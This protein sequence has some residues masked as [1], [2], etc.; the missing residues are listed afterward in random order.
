MCMRREEMRRRLAARPRGV[1]FEELRALLEAYG[2]AVVRIRGSHHV[3][4]RAGQTLAVPLR[5]PHVLA[6]YVREALRLTEED[7]A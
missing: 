4:A 2:W 7:P 6:T 1:R 5:R 3:F